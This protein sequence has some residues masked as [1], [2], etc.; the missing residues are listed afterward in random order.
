MR[1]IDADFFKQ[2]IAAATLKNNIEPNKV[3]ALIE[4]VE[5]QPTAFDLENAVGKLEDR[6]K[7]TREEQSK[8]CIKYGGH[9]TPEQSMRSG[10][11]KG[12]LFS[13]QV[14]KSAADAASG[15]DG[16]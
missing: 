8:D 14:L 2:Q 5:A 7:Y 6:L 16:G 12:L 4:I 13:L 9:C 11:I 3:L 1:L 15:K 10:I